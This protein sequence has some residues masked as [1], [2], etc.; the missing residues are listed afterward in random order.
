M[1]LES[2][3]LA[4]FTINKRSYYI[5]RNLLQI[6]KIDLFNQLSKTLFFPK[7]YWSHRDE[8][9][10]KILFGKIL[11]S[12]KIPTIK[13]R[14]HISGEAF[15]P[16]FYGGRSFESDSTKKNA[17]KTFR[18]QYFFLPQYEIIQ[19]NDQ[20]FLY[21]Y[22][23]STIPFKNLKI[24]LPE[25][26]NESLDEEFHFKVL[27]CIH[28]PTYCKWEKQ[29]SALIQEIQN[30]K[31]DKAVIARQSTFKLD[32]TLNPYQVLKK[33]QKSFSNSS[34]FSF[35]FKAGAAF[36]G[37]T[38]EC[39]YSRRYFNLK[40]EAIAG[41]C[42]LIE[43]KDLLKSPKEI[44]EFSYVT[45]FLSDK[46]KKMSFDLQKKQNKIVNI[47]YLKHLY[48]QYEAK[49]LP[50]VSDEEIINS[51]FPS[52]ALSG[53]PQQKA[54]KKIQSI[55]DFN[56][57]WYA[58]PIGCISENYAELIIAIRSCLI[59]NMKIHLFVGNG[60]V[61]D[62]DPKKEWEELDIKMKPFLSLLKSG[63]S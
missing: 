11:G 55:E 20:H 57:H 59:S 4:I 63:L 14:E 9:E 27:N 44:D 38:P 54:L 62:S 49:L 60:I 25:I 35:Q 39:L 28:S 56:R 3:S 41:T 30:K 45:T 58:S 21:C 50:K 43:K 10:S 46:L 31:L 32:Q 42:S 40:T 17:F 8:E 16:K 7:V 2:S 6:A 15:E 34:F 51:L 13:L 1:N 47:G 12:Y 24:K 22:K 5:A 23:I 19:K 33:I 48:S 26:F 29:I 37:A 61:K 52:P 36:L 53:F 18:R